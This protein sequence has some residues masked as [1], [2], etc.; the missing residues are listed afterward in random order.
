MF[1]NVKDAFKEQYI[2]GVE[3]AEGLTLVVQKD[4]EYVVPNDPQFGFGE[5]HPHAGKTIRY[6]FLEG[7]DERY[8]DNKSKRFQSALLQAGASVGDEIT[9]TRTGQ[10]TKTDWIVNIVKKAE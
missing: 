4:A 6:F 3:F 10:S 9:I 2:K 1:E 8:F 7:E 5:D